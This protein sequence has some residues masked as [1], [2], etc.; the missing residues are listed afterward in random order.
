MTTET[1]KKEPLEAKETKEIT[2]RCKYCGQNKPLSE[3]RRITRFFPVLIA[4]RD[5][6]RKIG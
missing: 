4:C 6:E 2:F 3:M 5:C 1:S